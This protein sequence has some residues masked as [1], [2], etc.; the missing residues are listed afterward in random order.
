M[1]GYVSGDLTTDEGSVAFLS[2]A[3]QSLEVAH[4]LNCPRL[5]VHG[6]GLDN[7]GRRCIRASRSLAPIG[8][9]RLRRSAS[10]RVSVSGLGRYSPWRI[11]IRVDHPGTPFA[12]SED[13]ARLVREVGSS[14]LRLNY[15]I[16]H[17]Q[18][19]EGN[20]IERILGLLP[21][22]VEIQVAD[23][24]GRQEP[25]TGEINYPAIARA[26]HGADYEGII[27]LEAWAS[28]DPDAALDRFR[29]AFQGAAQA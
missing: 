5:N 22:V 21:W 13:T 3:E 26:F 25:G 29:E 17:A 1:T 18:I 8:S 6:T 28:G 24:P 10:W 9:Q 16:Y 7:G 20:L 19:D 12:R 14:A 2:S 15:D 27:A 4:L 23:V 11:S